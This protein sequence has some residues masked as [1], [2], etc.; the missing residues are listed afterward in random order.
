MP[1]TSGR[2][3]EILHLDAA[4]RLPGSTLGVVSN[5]GR[6]FG[7]GSCWAP[8][9]AERR[10]WLRAPTPLRCPSRVYPLFKPGSE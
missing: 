9:E 3:G 2:W 8:V 1:M 5:D 7:G 6:L 10:R 4:P